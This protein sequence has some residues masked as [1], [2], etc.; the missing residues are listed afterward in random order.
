MTPLILCC[1]AP[2]VSYPQRDLLIFNICANPTSDDFLSNHIFLTITTPK[3]HQCLW[4]NI[5]QNWSFQFQNDR[6]FQVSFYF[7]F[8]QTIYF[9]FDDF[10]T[11]AVCN[12]CA[13]L[14][15]RFAH[16]L[17]GE[18][19]TCFT[20]LGEQQNSEHTPTC[21]CRDRRLRVIFT[22]LPLASFSSSTFLVKVTN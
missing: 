5:E 3:I 20:L 14:F 13:Y 4:I 1:D 15:I 11:V 16:S 9:I 2:Q 7:S 12:L 6:E 19:Y 10:C 8:P 22:S 21:S 18:R 17:R